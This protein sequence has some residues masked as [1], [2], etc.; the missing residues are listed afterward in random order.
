LRQQRRRREANIV[1]GAGGGEIV[2]KIAVLLFAE[3]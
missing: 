3:L 2:E 1:R